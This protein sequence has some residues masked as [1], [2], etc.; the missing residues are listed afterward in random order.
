MRAA[1]CS[2]A[3]IGSV[4]LGMSE[5]PA[6]SANAERQ[7]RFR[8]RRKAVTESGNVTHNVTGDVTNNATRNVT[9][10][11]PRAPIHAGVL[12]GEGV[13]QE[14]KE[15]RKEEEALLAE[16]SSTAEMALDLRADPVEKKNTRKSR[17]RFGRNYSN[18]ASNGMRWRRG[19]DCRRSI[20]SSPVRPGKSRHWRGFAISGRTSRQPFRNFWTASADPPSSPARGDSGRISIGF[21]TPRISRK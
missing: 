17:S 3:Q 20:S 12:Y 13:K 1:G 15:E 9:S 21:A 11:T 4:V 10:V 16:S 6:R 2:D 7:A 8:A 19:A 14:R 18:S 5:A